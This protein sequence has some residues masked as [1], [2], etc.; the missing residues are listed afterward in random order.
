M[1]I[2][3]N[4]KER[5]IAATQTDASRVYAASKVAKWFSVFVRI[6]I[7]GH[8]IWQKEWPENL[9]S[10]VEDGKTLEEGGEK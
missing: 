10:Q 2:S 1:S 7:F 4:E 9:F 3:L 8:V 5:I 6:S